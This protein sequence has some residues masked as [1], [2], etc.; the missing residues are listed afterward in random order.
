MKKLLALLLALCCV[1]AVISCGDDKDGN[2]DNT[3]QPEAKTDLE[4]FTEMLATSV[5]TQSV[6][7][8]TEKYYNLSLVSTY[9]LTSGTY[10]DEED[11]VSKK[12]TTL[13]SV[14]QTLQDAAS[15]YVDPI[16]S[17]TTREWYIEGKG[18]YKNRRL[19]DEDGVDFAPV[20]G[21]LSLDLSEEHLSSHEYNAETG[22]MVIVV[23]AESAATVLASFIKKGYEFEEDVTIT[24]VA[25][26][27][28][29]SK[30]DINYI[31]PEHDA[32][33]EDNE[34]TMVAVGDIEVSISTSYYYNTQEINLD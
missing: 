11:G 10:V 23:K 29:I 26:G 18:T 2:T 13:I 4:K 20:A 31:I 30:I 8:A 6:A 34:D 32:G 17:T 33:D 12:A 14:V 5:P 21:S 3:Q 7:V 19:V 22:K 28:R 15:G 24:I 16:K 25:A 27:D 9:T 1:F